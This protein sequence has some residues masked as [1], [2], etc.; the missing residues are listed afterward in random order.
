VHRSNAVADRAVCFL[1]RFLPKL[2]GTL[3]VPPFLS[4]AGERV[5]QFAPVPDQSRQAHG[6]D[7]AALH[8]LSYRR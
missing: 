4:R 8:D 7:S 5:G 3:G 6:A 1:G 2:G